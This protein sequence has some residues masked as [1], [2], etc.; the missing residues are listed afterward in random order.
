MSALAPRAKYPTFKFETPGT[1]LE[2]VVSQPTEDF[3]AR[4]F[5]TDKLKFWPDGNP[6][7]QTRIV[8]QDSAPSEWAIYA[9]GRMAKAITAAIRAAGAED[10]EVGGYLAV[11]FTHYGEGKNPAMPPKE[12]TANYTPPVPGQGVPADPWA[13]DEPPF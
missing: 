11:T 3:Q 6:V 12:Y 13:D 2:G 1:T 5:G 8:V 10:L 9:Q 4:E 7:M